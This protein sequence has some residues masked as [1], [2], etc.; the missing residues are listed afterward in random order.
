MQRV[1][2]SEQTKEAIDSGEN[3]RWLDREVEQKEKVPV[4]ISWCSWRGDQVEGVSSAA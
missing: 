1:P 3:F 2:P 4:N